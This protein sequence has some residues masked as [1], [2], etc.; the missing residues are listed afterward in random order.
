MLII[1]EIRVVLNTAKHSMREPRDQRKCIVILSACTLELPFFYIHLFH[2][3]FK[4]DYVRDLPINEWLPCV[5]R[6]P[7]HTA[8]SCIGRGNVVVDLRPKIHFWSVITAT[9]IWNVQNLL[10]QRPHQTHIFRQ[11]STPIPY[12]NI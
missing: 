5:T 7:L 8:S 11:P 9:T 3:I 6:T 1:N 10:W 12:S 2:A 4:L